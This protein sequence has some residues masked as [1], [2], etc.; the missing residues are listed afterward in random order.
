MFDFVLGCSGL[1]AT[2]GINWKKRRALCM[3]VALGIAVYILL[4]VTPTSLWKKM[5]INNQF[6]LSGRL[7]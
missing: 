2:L 3:V 1:I 6:I 7:V 4:K 5:R